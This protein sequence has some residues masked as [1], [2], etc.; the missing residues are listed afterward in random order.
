MIQPSMLYPGHGWTQISQQITVSVLFHYLKIQTFPRL[1]CLM[2]KVRQLIC[3]HCHYVTLPTHQQTQ[4]I[5]VHSFTANILGT[6]ALLVALDIPGVSN[7]AQLFLFQNDLSM[8][9]QCFGIP[10]L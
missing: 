6:Q 8:P 7:L 3:I 1:R 2:F 5:L 9:G 4:V 10:L